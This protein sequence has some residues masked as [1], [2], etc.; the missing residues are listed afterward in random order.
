LSSAADLDWLKQVNEGRIRAEQ[1]EI[2]G[3]IASI[4]TKLAVCARALSKIVTDIRSGRGEIFLHG[5]KLLNARPIPTRAVQLGAAPQSLQQHAELEVLNYFLESRVIPKYIGVSKLCCAMCAGC[6][7]HIYSRRIDHQ[8][9][10][11]RGKSGIRFDIRVDVPHA[12]R[13]AIPDITEVE[14]RAHLALLPTD[15]AVR[16]LMHG[17]NL[18]IARKSP[19]TPPRT[20][21]LKEWEKLGRSIVEQLIIQ[22]VLPG[23][24][25]GKETIFERISE[26]QDHRVD[27]PQVDPPPRRPVEPDAG[28]TRIAAQSRGALEYAAAA[29]AEGGWT[30]ARRGRHISQAADDAET[31]ATRARQE[32]STR[33]AHWIERMPVRAPGPTVHTPQAA[34]AAPAAHQPQYG[35]NPVPSPKPPV[36]AS[37][38]SA[39]APAPLP[40]MSGT[41]PSGHPTRGKER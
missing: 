39:P 9:L 34:A 16:H 15:R 27:D 36:K 21:E 38:A 25:A 14:R 19:T 2:A 8:P 29:E 35:P 17:P 20:T 6:L 23:L 28:N 1:A 30:V 41:Q 10:F 3:R 24:A 26:G 31:A 33:L 37:P 32:A 22:N 40:R 7:E 5:I 13:I 18:A 4:H 11:V 12:V